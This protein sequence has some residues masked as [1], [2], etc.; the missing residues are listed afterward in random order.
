M[1][2]T[3]VS[4]NDIITSARANEI[5]DKIEQGTAKIA[6]LSIDIGGTSLIAS[7]R[8]IADA[9]VGAHKIGTATHTT[10]YGVGTNLTGIS[11]GDM[12]LIAS[13]TWSGIGTTQTFSSLDL[14]TDK[15]YIL[16]FSGRAYT[17]S[18]AIISFYVNGD[19]TATNYYAQ[20]LNLSGAGVTAARTNNAKCGTTGDTM[21]FQGIINIVHPM[22]GVFKAISTMN[23]HD[24]GAV[25]KWESCIT[26]SGG[27]SNITSIT[28][29][30]SQN[31][32]TG[33]KFALYRRKW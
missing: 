21:R 5:N 13:N 18:G 11:S 1:T 16:I 28:I 20:T 10:F 33:A 25:E 6:T 8:D 15:E 31:I 23:T 24:H 14:A 4:A 29:S 3:D 9:E 22:V 2:L 17:A 7:D 12:E 32:A 27:V 30:S 26:D 19:T